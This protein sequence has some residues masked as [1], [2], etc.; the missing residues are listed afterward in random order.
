MAASPVPSPPRQPAPT[1]LVGT[2]GPPELAGETLSEMRHPMTLATLSPFSP[3]TL[4]WIESEAWRDMFA[5][6]P[7]AVVSALG[8]AASLVGEVA[9]LAGPGVPISEL[10][11]AFRLDDAL[12]PQ[13]ERIVPWLSALAAPDFALQIPAV[14]AA[15]E[16]RRKAQAMGFKA[17]G[18]GWS[19]FLLDLSR[20]R[21]SPAPAPAIKLHRDPDG[22]VYSD[23]VVRAFGLPDTSRAW[24]AALAGRA[25]WTLFVAEIDG[26]PVGS[27]AAY[28]K[29]EWAWFGIG[30]TIEEARRQGVQSALIQARLQAAREAGVRYVTAETGRPETAEGHHTSRDNYLRSG[31][32]EA[33]VRSNFKRSV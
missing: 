23:L 26:Q 13:L 2:P 14:G 32:I 33:Y 16:L 19:K 18:N 29:G 11:R 20:P 15:D 30:G 5:A 28:I 25:D 24:F 17:A 10:N 27:G 31:F 22:A 21:L 4:E 3:A 1:G 12:A 8:L 9:V 7:G 6:A